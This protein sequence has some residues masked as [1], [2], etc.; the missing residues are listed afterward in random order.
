MKLQRT[1]VSRSI[2]RT[3]LALGMLAL[4]AASAV[5]SALPPIG[6]ACPS[7]RI[8][9]A[10][11]RTLDLGTLT[12]KPLLVVYEDKDSATQNQALKDELAK[13]AKGDVYRSRI[14]LVAVADLT[15]YDYWPVRGFVKDAI[16]AESNKQGTSIFCDWDGSFRTT[17][18]LEQG[19]S[20]VVLYGKDGRVL[21][22]FAG[23]MSPAQRQRLVAL[24]QAQL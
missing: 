24:L 19:M 23:A 20:N 12:G 14:T 6:R 15:G 16:Q 17:L 1:V 22:G 10:W 4:L 9:D 7:A 13:L 5:A 3:A 8:S 21:A 11:E 2:R 18:A